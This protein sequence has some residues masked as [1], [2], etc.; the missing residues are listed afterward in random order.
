M[1]CLN[2]ARFRQ[3]RFLRVHKETNLDP[4]P[5]VVLVLQV[6]DTEKFPQALGFKSLYPFFSSFFFRVNEQ[7]PCFT[8]IEEDGGN[9]RLV[10]LELACLNVRLCQT[11]SLSL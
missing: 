9:K 10:E 4:H 8:A 3:K 1:T 2:Y 6:G 5:V 11:P 7:S